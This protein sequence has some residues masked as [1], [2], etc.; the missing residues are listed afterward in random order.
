[1]QNQ[2][3]APATTANVSL[4]EGQI[5]L[6]GG[7]S[8]CSG[9]VEINFSGRWGTV[10]DDLWDV[11]DAQVVCR[12]LGCGR[13]L[14]APGS[15]RFG[16]GS[17]P[18]WLD[19]VRC[20][21][22]ESSLSEC[23]HRG[24]GSHDCSHREDAGVVCEAAAPVRLVNSGSRCTG[25]V[26]IF[27]NNQWGT[28]C[29]DFWDL[30][31]ANVV[32][33]QLDCGRARSAPQNAAYGQGSGPIWLDDVN[34]SGRENSI[35]DCRHRGFGI[36]NCAHRED[37]SVV[38]EDTDDSL[39]PSQLVC[40]SSKIQVG[41]NVV[42]FL[43]L[44]LDARSGNLAMRNCTYTRVS[45][46]V[47]WYEVVNQ[48]GACG[49]KLTTNITHGI[50]SNTLFVYPA[51]NNSFAIPKRIPFSCVYSLDTDSTLNVAVGPLPIDGGVS[52]SG[53]NTVA[54]M[55]LYRD[56]GFTS[57]YP[58]GRV[59]MELG[60]PLYVGVTVDRRDQSFAV[61]LDDCYASHSPRPSSFGR[62]PLINNKCSADRRQVAVIENGSSLRARF[63]ALFFLLQGEYRDVY[64]HC[65]LSLC[66]RRRTSCVPSCSR[67]RSR[68]VSDSAPLKSLT[69]G[70]IV[71]NK[72]SK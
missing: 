4:A 39:R 40:S 46:G 43:N 16:Q 21:G 50:Y 12:Q 30:N 26:E 33:R 37:A 19:D 63:S 7:N 64:L 28:V 67:R 18:I 15:A 51:N 61:V 31:D 57:T 70:P 48:A 72:P 60:S 25:R 35:T 9:R 34:C 49:N 10:C 17:G 14:S 23:R 29:D 8:S 54:Q 11:T 24:I 32:C 2:T 65:N 52:G 68:S 53:P 58:G 45:N 42:S 41:L 27:H 22:Q 36:H 13:V 38:C 66:D 20:N 59:T 71:F 3:S 6:I 47:V 55:R 44:G 62:Y 69:V 1:M 5:R 56:S